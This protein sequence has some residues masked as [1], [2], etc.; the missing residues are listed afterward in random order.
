MAEPLQ[1]PG[2][3]AALAVGD[4]ATS[5]PF[6][7]PRTRKFTTMAMS[8]MDR[9]NPVYSN[10]PTPTQIDPSGVWGPKRP[11]FT[12]QNVPLGQT[13]MPPMNPHNPVLAA[14]QPAADAAPVAAVAPAGGGS[15]WDVLRNLF[16]GGG[17]PAQGMTGMLQ[18]GQAGTGTDTLG[19]PANRFRSG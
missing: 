15:L 5:N 17:G 4:R 8:I 18:R 10:M 3:V 12:P 13:P 19:N 6:F 11:M 9:N 14:N 1:L 2:A 16:S 7:S